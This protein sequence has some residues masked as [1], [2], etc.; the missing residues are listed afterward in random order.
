MSLKID[1][2]KLLIE[3][4][5]VLFFR[6]ARPFTAASR[7]TSVLA[8]PQTIAGAFRTALLRQHNCDF[9]AMRDETD[10]VAAVKKG[11]PQ[12]PWIANVTFRGPWFCKW[13]NNPQQDLN[14]LVPVP[15]NLHGRKKQETGPLFTLKP[16][17]NT[18]LPG[19]PA[20]NGLQP[21]W[22]KSLESTE[23]SEGF[24]GKDGLTEYLSGKKV[25]REHLVSR[26]ELYGFDN[27]TGIGINPDRL[28]SEESLIYGVSFLALKNKVGIY[29]E[30]H[31]PGKELKKTIDAIELISLGG[32]GRRARVTKLPESTWE[33]PTA[34]TQSTK[35]GD[36][37]LLTTPGLFEQDPA[38][39]SCLSGNIQAASVPGSVAV[40]GWDMARRGP[41]RSRFAALPGSVYFLKQPMTTNNRTSLSDH[42]DDAALGWGC[43]L[44]GIWNDD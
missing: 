17:N 25:S 2:V 3:P 31:S 9:E 13:E 7:G 36:F 38:I 35:G 14:V 5:D 26:D 4:L 39:P 34:T 16:L 44:R 21:L 33:W 1:T 15:S 23:P 41:K 24:I 6:D 40:S 8:T 19:W 20:N 43:Y 27:R 29:V 37:V 30:L 42:K 32:E 12:A 10:F 22:L 18:P 11:C 28:T